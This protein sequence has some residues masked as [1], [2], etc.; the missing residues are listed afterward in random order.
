MSKNGLKNL[1]AYEI[2]EDRFIE[3][4]NTQGTLLRHKKTGARVA[5]L[6]N[7]DDN[8]V[9]YIGFRTPPADSTGVAH[10]VEHTVLCGSEHFPVK[11]PFIELAKGSL[12]TFLNAMTF[13]DKTVYPVASCNDK[14]FQ[15]LMHVYLDSVFY[16][17]IYKEENIF[18]QE[19]WHYELKDEN[20]P[21]TINGVV[22]SE[23]KGAFSSPD[24]VLE[25]EIMNSLYPDTSYGVESGGHPDV[26]PELT[27]EDYLAFHKKFYHPSN[28]YIYLY[29]D[30]DMEEKLR[31]IDEEYLCKFDYLEV[32]S[33]IKEQPAFDGCRESVIEYPISETESEEDNAYLSFNA[34]VGKS[35]D[36]ELYLAFAILDYAICSAP[37]APLKKALIDK[38]IG[39]D[40]YSTYENGIFQPYFSVI[41]KNT[42]ADRKEEFLETI[43][44]VLCNLVKEG[45]DRKALAAAI[46]YYEFRYRE[47]DFGSY[48]KGLMYGLTVLDSWLYDDALAFWHIEANDMYR[49]M[50]E[51]IETDYFEELI[52]KY[53]I[54]NSH[55]SVV[56]AVPVKGLTEKREKQLEESLTAYKNSL[57]SEEIQDIIKKAEALKEYQETP[58]SKEALEC[59]PLL[60]REDMRKEVL[61]FD[62]TVKDLAGSTFLHHD[63]FTNGIGYVRISFDADNIP[64]E[65][66][67][68]TGILK[69]VIGYMD[70]AKRKYGELFHEVHLLTGGFSTGFHVY[71]D[72]MENN[73]PHLYYEV[74]MKV[75]Y[76][77]M[78]KAFALLE[79]ILLE[80]SFEDTGRLYEIV[81]EAKSR[82]QSQLMASGHSAAAG[83][84]ASYL[85]GAAALMEEMSGISYYRFLEDTER[86]FDACK[87]ELVSKLKELLV[88]ILRPENVLLD[89]TSPLKEE[90]GIGKAFLSLKGRLFQ[91]E[92]TDA[93]CSVCPV[94]K[95]EG[96][97]NSAKVQYVCRAGKYLKDDSD[98][99]GSLKV[100]RTI[101]GYDY[102][103]GRVRVEGGAYGCMSAFKRN[104][105]GY[106]VSY[107]D[108]NLTKTNQVFEEVVEYLEGYEADEREMTQYIIGTM[109]DEDAPL[110]PVARGQRSYLAYRMNVAIE[111][112]Q[113]E[114]DELL[115][116]TEKEIRAL[117]PFMKNMLEADCI[118]VVGNT[119]AIGEAAE[120]FEKIEPLFH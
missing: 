3:D 23:M 118:C 96:F 89:Y 85:S 22:Y 51:R 73:K 81:A 74:K 62:N 68:Y 28:S 26:I 95:N 87:E 2:V 6:S 75:L 84:A 88:R 30:M 35:V 53:L 115:A 99:T 111:T 119:T 1:A 12:N 70:T 90:A 15:N 79:E 36:R 16:P 116:T 25:R 94:K 64:A 103:W 59:I 114:R 47:A 106:F 5:L 120:L 48:P 37:G 57:T 52:Q 34:V 4:L 40:V 13:P 39:K 61:P 63:I 98:Y 19:G 21:L 102:L 41:S 27:Y 76:E 11:D 86:N 17:N 112:L 100:L 113:K 104:G 7:N 58:D 24:D 65:L 18:R 83:R 29:G 97:T 10:I 105:L 14:D 44:E 54:D 77:N 43:Q 38:G 80:T 117:A 60:K 66:L 56:T 45:V 33:V 69:N 32:D 31:F 107:R 46:Q 109:S 92:I 93:D 8:K 91:T 49:L 108:P 82:M 42:N 50:K 67:P 110:T 9:F 78:E 55:K 71:E 20:E 101:L 72:S